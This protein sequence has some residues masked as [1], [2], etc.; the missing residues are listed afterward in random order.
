MTRDNIVI[1]SKKQ[2]CNKESHFQ[3]PSYAIQYI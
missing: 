3:V 2:I 1:H